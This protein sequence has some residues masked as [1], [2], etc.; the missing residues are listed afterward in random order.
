MTSRRSTAFA[1]D[2]G[3]IVTER[4]AGRRVV[5]VTGNRG[6]AQRGVRHHP[7]LLRGAATARR[8]A[9]PGE[10][11]RGGR[12]GGGSRRA[13]IPITATTARCTCR[14]A[15]PGSSRRWSGSTTA[16]S[17]A[18]G[19]V[20]AIPRTRS[21]WPS[22][23]SRSITTSRTPAPPIRRSGSSRH[24]PARR[25]RAAAVRL[26]GERHPQP[27]LPQPDELRLSHGAG[28]STTSG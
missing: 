11:R 7:Q 8:G 4:H 23:R 26:S 6:A 13:S 20:R 24:R 27:V 18:P 14:P 10:P 16:A 19:A 22:R 28:R 2:H 3:L 15:W 21:S 12:G 25:Q 17:A 5:T 1:A 9:S